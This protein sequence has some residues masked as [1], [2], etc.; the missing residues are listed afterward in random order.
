MWAKLPP[1]VANSGLKTALHGNF[2][3]FGIHDLIHLLN[4]LRRD[5]QKHS[6][7]AGRPSAREP[8]TAP[9]PAPPLRFSWILVIFSL[10]K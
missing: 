8:D 6:A 3:A 9:R 7:G 4:W 10:K 5:H 2:K 1:F